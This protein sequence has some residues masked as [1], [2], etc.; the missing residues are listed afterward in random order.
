MVAG[1]RRGVLGEVVDE[2]GRPQLVADELL[3]DVLD[4]LA[5][6]GVVVDLQAD[7]LGVGD[8]LL[9][10]GL[11]GDL[12]TEGLGDGG[13]EVDLVP[14]ARQVVLGAVG[15]RDDLAA[16]RQVEGVPGRLLDEV[17]GQLGHAVVVGVGL[18]GL[19]GRELRGVGGVG[20]LVA[21]VAVDLEDA[22]HTADHSALEV[23]LR[24]DAQVEIHVEGVHVGDER[25]RGRPAVN[26]L[27]HGGLQL[28]VVA[29]EEVLADGAHDGGAG[30]HHV[31]GGG[32][33]E[34][35]E[36]TT[37]HALLLRERHRLAGLVG[38]GLGQGS[39]RLGGDPPGGDLDVVVPGGGGLG[40]LAQDRLGHDGQ[41]AAARGDDAAV[42]EEVV[43]QV[44]VGLEGRERGVALGG[45][46]LGREHGLQGG[47]GTVLQG[48]EAQAAGVAQE[49]DAAGDTD[50]VVG[51]LPGLEVGVALAHGG[52][53]GGDGHGDRVGVP[54]LAAQ[55]LALAGADLELLARARVGLGLLGLVRLLRLSAG[56]VGGGRVGAG[57]ALVCHVKESNGAGP[58]RTPP[59]SRR[60]PIH[61][62]SWSHRAAVPPV[63]SRWARRRPR[64]RFPLPSGCGARTRSTRPATRWGP[65][66]RP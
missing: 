49:D 16:L 14:L 7:L 54:A 35:V 22:V 66:P 59:G 43:A 1:Q 13:V 57:G 30:A 64:S 15:Q 56:G 46:G 3:E 29:A 58:P 37:A 6:H 32:P 26:D 24:G 8:Q 62:R 25:A 45:Q 17:A 65:G 2:G 53:G 33:G 60:R 38:P 50:D 18:V 63:R 19:Q 12:L 44:D 48:D 40:A 42:D 28:Q 41:L 9:A 51:L 39:Q 20:A 4:D 55:A 21:E 11:H 36:L 47:A 34:Q 5:G 10:R 31:A 27:Q 52:D 61:L 23:D